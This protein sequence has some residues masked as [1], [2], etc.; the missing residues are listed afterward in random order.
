MDFDTIEIPFS[1]KELGPEEIEGVVEEIVFENPD[2]GFFVAK[3]RRH[4]EN[5]VV[6]IVGKSFPLSVGAS[7]KAYGNWVIHPRYGLQFQ[8]IRAEMLLP[9]SAEA[10]YKFL[11]SGAIPGIGPGYARRIINT[12]REDVLYVLNHEP[13]KL[14]RVSG[15]GKN[16]ARKIAEAWREQRDQFE[17]MLTL[18]QYNI[19]PSLA[20]KI[21]KVYGNK[22]LICL[23]EDPYKLANEVQGIG[24]KTADKIAKDMGLDLSNPS[25]IEA[26]IKYVL[27]EG[28]ND[29]H[30]FL[31]EE[32]LLNSTSTL[33]ELPIDS[34]VP[35]YQSLIESQKLVRDGDAVYLP[36]HYNIEMENVLHLQRIFFGAS[37]LPKG[38]PIDEFLSESHPN[39]PQLNEEQRSALRV[40]LNSKISVVTGGPGTGKTTLIK[41]LVAFLREYPIRIALTAPTGRAG[42]QMESVTGHP[43]STIHRLLE[44][45]PQTGK[46]MRDRDNPICADFLIVDETSM[47][48]HVLLYYL[49]RAVPTTT[50]IVFVGDVDQLPSVGPGNVLSDL[51]MSGVFPVTRLKEVFRQSAESGIITNAHRINRGE[52]PEFN[53][54]DFFFIRRVDSASALTTLLHIVVER[55]PQRF[56][57][58]PIKDIQVLA[59]L[60]RGDVGVHHLNLQLQ[61]RL[62]SE[63]VRIPHTPFRIGDKVMQIRNNYEKE[64]FNGDVGIIVD[65]DE[66]TG[67]I[68][69]LFEG[70]NLV[71][72]S[73]EQTEQLA[74]AYSA[75]VHK[76]Q[77]CEYPVVILLMLPQHYLL[78]QRNVLYTAVTRAKKMVTII[79]S[80]NAI[81][82]ALKTTQSV[83]RNTRLNDRLRSAFK[84]NPVT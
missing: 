6:L 49:L 55:I 27:Q 51:I 68:Q 83:R 23:R 24:F 34:I 16:R 40:A 4:Q 71:V 19:S 63:G 48:D 5:N 11:S 57:Y 50:H 33:L 28:E 56:G 15:L 74:L 39:L 10:I 36:F 31:Y 70:G 61:D 30:V 26:G 75:T 42:K 60:R 1:P 81:Q 58:D 65:A 20:N 62:N 84:I 82:K 64:V 32:G 14:E 22:T 59:P 9:S 72:Y 76:S 66:D 2:T 45:N 38:L 79:G 7:I 54:K 29:G 44:F 69:V 73:L 37:A 18:Q 53:Q 17:T 13:E 8:V 52:F 67:L 46:P 80:P 43:A 41:T 78:L 25:R 77:G 12:F 47:V 3:L 21:Y 35:V